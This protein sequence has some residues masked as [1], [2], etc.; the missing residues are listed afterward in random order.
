MHTII[1]LEFDCHAES[2]ESR[3]GQKGHSKVDL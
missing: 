3:L 2:L 1:F